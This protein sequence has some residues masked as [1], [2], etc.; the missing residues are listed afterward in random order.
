MVE[1]SIT[2]V[3]RMTKRGIFP[4]AFGLYS[5]L[6]EYFVSMLLDFILRLENPTIAGIDRFHIATSQVEW[7]DSWPREDILGINKLWHDNG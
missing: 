5:D 1:V 2:I 3:S 6:H 4:S 7:P